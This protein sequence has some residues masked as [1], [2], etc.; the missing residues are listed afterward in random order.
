MGWLITG[1]VLI[2]AGIIFGILA[3]LSTIVAISA[4]EDINDYED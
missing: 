1:I 3:I 2:V 4:G